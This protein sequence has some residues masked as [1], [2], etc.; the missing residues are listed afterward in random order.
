VLSPAEQRLREFVRAHHDAD[1]ALLERAVNLASGTQ[2]VAGVRRVGDRF[3]AELAA[4][5]FAVR[6]A[7]VP[8]EMRRAGHLVAERRGTKGP[9]LLL[10]GHLDTVFEG[11]G[12]RFVR[13]DTIAR[14]AGT[15]DMKGGDVAMI[16]ALRALNAAGV[17]D[18]SQ[19]I[20]IMTGDEEAPGSPLD[21]ARKE[22]ID[23]A[24]RSDI[25]L[26][27]EGGLA[28]RASISR[29]GASNWTLTATG[30]QGH[31]SRIFSPGFGHGS[32]Y[33]MARILDTFRR[34]LAGD[35]TLTFNPG[36][37]GG[38]TDVKR[39]SSGTSVT[40]SGK[41]NIISPSAVA[42]GDLRFLRESQKD[43]TRARMRTIVAQHLPGTDAQITFR[44]GYPAMP[45]SPQGIALLS[46][47]DA[48]SRSLGYGPVMS[49]PPESRGAGDVSFVAPYLPG[50]DGLGVSGQ[51]AHS[52]QESVNLNSL[53]MAAERAAVFMHR[54]I[55]GAR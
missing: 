22:L 34:E 49:D 54:L 18:G 12:Q 17:L 23:A 31:S 24:K 5:G 51:G 43:S 4:L 40:V 48:V 36:L 1:I 50:M 30:Q 27:F 26:A 16:A 9:R 8:S 35:P 21:V 55:T 20:V 39:D 29:R 25:A 47:F 2:N 6:W 15:A 46:Q 44:D 52:P 3:S 42:S 7:D 53:T 38:G 28:G 13:E 45:P 19:I 32:I 33:E 41:T 11:E 37:I 10:I 14:G